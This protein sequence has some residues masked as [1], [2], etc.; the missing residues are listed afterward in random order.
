MKIKSSKQELRQF[1]YLMGGM[2][3][4][5]FGL[6]LPW[7]LKQQLPTWPWIVTLI[8]LTLALLLP[9]S[10]KPV[11]LLWM[12]F[13]QLMGWINTRIILGLVFVVIFSPVGLLMRLIRHDPLQR[14]L[15]PEATSYRIEAKQSIC[16]H[17]M[18]NPY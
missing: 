14:R 17:H 6:F 5:L 11:Y 8:F 3:A 7:V 18:E 16:G 10:L 15:L 1:G 4:L 2:V 9:V 12:K 13:G